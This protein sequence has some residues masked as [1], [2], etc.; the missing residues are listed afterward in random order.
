LIH[1]QQA[2]LPTTG[3]V[4]SICDIVMMSERI[5]RGNANVN[6]RP[7]ETDLIGKWVKK[8]TSVV[9]DPVEVRIN[10]LIAHDLQKLAVSAASGSWEILYRDPEDGRYWELTYPHGEMHGGGP[11]RLTNLPAIAAIAKYRPSSSK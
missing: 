2:L 11:K 6:L 7:E 5:G 10:R 8:G 9:A 4:S 3:P 1:Q